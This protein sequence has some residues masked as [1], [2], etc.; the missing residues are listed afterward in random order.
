M[1]EDPIAGFFPLDDS[2]E[3]LLRRVGEDLWQVVA[4]AAAK[5]EIRSRLREKN[6]GTSHE[7][8]CVLRD[9]ETNRRQQA[10]R[11]K[12]ILYLAGIVCLEKEESP[13]ETEWLDSR[14]VLY[15]A[16]V[17]QARIRLRRAG[18]LQ[19]LNS[20]SRLQD[21]ETGLWVELSERPC[22]RQG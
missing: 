16:R 4:L 22:E 6:P 13:A 2:F 8:A 17:L 7:C 18:F 1:V 9:E 10:Q 14:F 19:D 21:P 12:E 15:V 3:L 11:V 5:V 20:A